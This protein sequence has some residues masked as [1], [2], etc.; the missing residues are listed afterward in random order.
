M[1]AMRVAA[2]EAE[3]K[4]ATIANGASLSGAVDLG[5]GAVLAAIY[6]PA[7]WTAASLTFQAS[8]DGVTYVDVYDDG[9]VEYEIAAA[10]SR[11]IKVSLEDFI[12]VRYL[13]VRSGTTATPVA[14]GASRSIVLVVSF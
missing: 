9:D 2:P 10:A 4:T 3:N 12:G 13:K 11:S 5:A 7:A 8:A 6:M 1:P 14:Q